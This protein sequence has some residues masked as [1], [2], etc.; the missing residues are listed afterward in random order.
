[1]GRAQLLTEEEGCNGAHTD[2]LSCHV[3]GG[4]NGRGMVSS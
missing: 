1:M 2:C 4:D 3:G